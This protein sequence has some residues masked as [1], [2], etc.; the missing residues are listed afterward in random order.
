MFPFKSY[1]LSKRYM[2]T[3]ILDILS[4]TK[5]INIK[6][7]EHDNLLGF[8]DTNN[9][10]VS[11]NKNKVVKPL[12]L[13]IKNNNNLQFKNLV[14]KSWIRYH[15][16]KIELV[17]GSI[18]LIGKTS[19]Y[20]M[21][22]K[23]Q[24]VL[25]NLTTNKKIKA[26]VNDT[27]GRSN[28]N[29]ISISDHYASNFHA[30]INNENQKYYIQDNDST[31]GVII[32]PNNQTVPIKYDDNLLIGG[33][34][35]KINKYNHGV[36]HDIGKRHSFED[37]YQVK[38]SLNLNSKFKTQMSYFAVFDGHS[39]KQT[40]SY[41]KIY[42]HSELEKQLNN[43]SKNQIN[44]DNI[45]K[46]CIT[47]AILNIDNTIFS[48]KI[49]SGTT[50]NIC[51]IYNNKLYTANVGD[52]RSVLCRN[53]EAI[54]LSVDHKPYDTKEKNRIE[55]NSG[56]VQHGRVNGRLAVSRALGDNSLKHEDPKLSPLTAMP[57]ITIN[58]LTK[59]DEFIILACDGLWDVMSNQDVVDFIRLRFDK[60]YNIQQIAKELVSYAIQ[61]LNSSDNVTCLII[62]L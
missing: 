34:N 51:I 40:S 53:G 37:T 42:L 46:K 3:I 6:L 2:N 31:H 20:I 22:T 32:I 13:F 54:A 57:D 11:N 17:E 8:D 25:K 38:N 58:T 21:K 48:S 12:G 36:F 24:L 45:I 50:A 9:I 5:P 7:K 18:L 39:G 35:V 52:S 44:N 27:I 61:T 14:K 62:K 41:A 19:F 10:V 49:Q 60:D 16:Q 56:F 59:N 28:K 23:P 15:N 26:N 30:T 55:R 4:E 47:K 33:Y 43:I 29:K 1:F